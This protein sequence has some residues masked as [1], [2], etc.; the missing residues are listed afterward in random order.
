M[1]YRIVIERQ[2]QKDAEKIPDKFKKAIDKA[3]LFL[4][5]HPRPTNAIKLTD[6]DGYRIRT[7]NYRI[8]YTIDDAGKAVVIYRIKTRGETTYK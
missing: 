1:T 8:L 5:N 4:A 3:I 7:G 6:R 2:A